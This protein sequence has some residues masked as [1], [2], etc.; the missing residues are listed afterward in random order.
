[1]VAKRYT[2][3]RG[4]AGKMKV[5]AKAM[6]LAIVCGAKPHSVLYVIFFGKAK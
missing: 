6:A 4:G 1:M 5:V 3:P 2:C